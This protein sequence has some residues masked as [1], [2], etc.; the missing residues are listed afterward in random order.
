MKKFVIFFC[1]DE[2]EELSDFGADR[3]SNDSFS[4]FRLL[5]GETREASLS[6]LVTGLTLGVRS[7]DK[8]TL[9]RRDSKYSV[10]GI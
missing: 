2:S 4:I 3:S 9:E 7:G 10:T 1:G 8:W 6:R 5:G